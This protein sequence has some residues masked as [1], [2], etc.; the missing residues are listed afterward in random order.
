MLRYQYSIALMAE[1]VDALDSKSSS[2]KGV[3]VRFPLGAQNFSSNEL[4]F[5]Y[6]PIAFQHKPYGITSF[7]AAKSHFL[8]LSQ[9]P[10]KLESSCISAVNLVSIPSA[11]V[12]EATV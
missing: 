12:R 11:K 6:S 2:R 1:L 7:T 8:M 9:S 4:K 3:G 10:T 5:F